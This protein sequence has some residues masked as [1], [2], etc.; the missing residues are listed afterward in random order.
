MSAIAFHPSRAVMISVIVL[1]IHGGAAGAWS[2]SP[3]LSLRAGFTGAAMAGS[4]LEITLFRWPTDAERAPL[5]AALAATPPQPAAPV[6]AP[7]GRAAGPGGRGGRGAP[8]LSSPMA[9]LEAAVKA[10][11]TCGY[12]WGEGVTGYSIKYAWRAPSADGG[13]R[14][15]LVTDRRLGAHASAST[16]APGGAASAAPGGAAER[17]FTVIEMRLDGKGSGEAKASLN[18]NVVIDAAAK[19]LALDAYASAPALLKVIR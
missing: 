18:A 2:E 14:I 13:D 1:T 9:R 6:A 11:P 12:I 19:T 15:V 16:P 10:A 7:T 4:P 5:L 3:A 17:D 8:P